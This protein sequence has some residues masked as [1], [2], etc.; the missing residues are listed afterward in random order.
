MVGCWGFGRIS[1]FR[2]SNLNSWDSWLYVTG[3]KRDA[4]RSGSSSRP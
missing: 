4:V 3:S 1:G 2:A